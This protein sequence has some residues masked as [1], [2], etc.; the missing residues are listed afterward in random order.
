MTLWPGFGRARSMKGRYPLAVC[1]RW[2]L[3]PSPPGVG[4]LLSW[5]LHLRVLL[6]CIADC[7]HQCHKYGL[8][9][10][11]LGGWPAHHGTPR[12]ASCTVMM[13]HRACTFRPCCRNTT[14]F[15]LEA[16]SKEG[17]PGPGPPPSPVVEHLAPY[18]ARVT[19]AGGGRRDAARGPG[20]SLRRGEELHAWRAPD[21]GRCST[22]TP[23]GPAA[24][25]YNASWDAWRR[26][27]RESLKKVKASP[28]CATCHGVCD[29]FSM[30]KG[31]YKGAGGGTP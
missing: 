31:T 19:Q 30:P 23:R 16:V 14:S 18:W 11:C 7:D 1:E 27:L 20:E 13:M 3:A 26:M 21:T 10:P 6:A 24:S 5:A 2:Q 9:P 12:V 25:C 4:F 28:L 29:C 8:M 15:K 17:P 22:P